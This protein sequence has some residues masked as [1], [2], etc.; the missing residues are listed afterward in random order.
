MRDVAIGVPAGAAMTELEYGGH[1]PFLKGI[2]PTSESEK[3]LAYLANMAAWSAM[4]STLKSKKLTP[5]QKRTFFGGTLATTPAIHYGAKGI[6]RAEDIDK[7]VKALSSSASGVST[8]SDDMA[9]MTKNITR[10]VEGAIGSEDDPVLQKALENITDF[11]EEQKRTKKEV[12]ERLD[13]AIEQIG[14]ISE[15][16]QQSLESLSETGAKATQQTERVLGGAKS[17]GKALTSP[18]AHAAYG[19]L[20]GLLGAQLFKR[21]PRLAQDPVERRRRERMNTL[22]NVLLPV[23]GAGGGY[24]ASGGFKELPNQLKSLFNK[25]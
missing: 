9:K 24:A 4:P 1:L 11:T 13:A 2:E 20:A 7:A 25:E 21:D 3:T 18:G 16:N 17:V 23:L 10:Q 6:Q 22:L 14:D 12:M 8:A 19:G 5:G 15:G